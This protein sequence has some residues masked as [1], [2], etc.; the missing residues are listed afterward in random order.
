MAE[1]P[2]QPAEIRRWLWWILLLAVLAIVAL[3]FSYLIWRFTRDDPVRYADPEEHFKYGSTGGE[4]ESGISY[5]IWKV[6][7]KMFPE[8]L[9]GKTYTPGT[10]YVSSGFLYKPGQDLPI[11]VSRRNTQGLDRVFLNCAICHTG[12]VRG[13]PQSPRIIYTGMPSNTVDLEAFERFIF[14]CASDQRFNAPRILAEM[15]GIGAKDDLI[16]RFILRYY[17]IAF[18]RE[19]LLML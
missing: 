13:T 3:G 10:D 17:A 9:P 8:Y 5:C 19:R 7:P 1:A 18:M 12:S 15:E 11:G 6:L 2:D 16:N 4:R 14:A